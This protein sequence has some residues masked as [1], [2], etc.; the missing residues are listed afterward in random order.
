VTQ[1]VATISCTVF[2]NLRQKT[3]FQAEIRDFK[4]I[5]ANGQFK[6]VKKSSFIKYLRQNQ[7]EKIGLFG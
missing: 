1:K 4:K 2:P 3:D 6:C 5:S 7:D